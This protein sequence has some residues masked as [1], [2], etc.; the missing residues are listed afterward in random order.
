MN[1]AE[2][3]LKQWETSDLGPDRRALLRCAAAAELSEAGRYEEAREALGDLWRGIGERPETT[4]LSILTTAEVLLQCGA[5]SG[6]LG[7]ARKDPGA[8]ERAKDLLTEAIRKFRS[9]GQSQKA[10]EAQ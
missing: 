5:L 4:G 10:S 6:W 9:Q 3:S 7:I 2:I 8:Q 1:P